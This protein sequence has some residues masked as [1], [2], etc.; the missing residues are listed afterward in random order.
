MNFEYLPQ[1]IVT[2]DGVSFKFG[3]TRELIRE[4]LSELH[5]EDDK[6]VSF[7]DSDTG[8]KLFQ[9]RDVYQDHKPEMSLFFLGY[10][11]LDLLTEIEIHQCDQIKVI[12]SSFSFD[13][14]LDSIAV[15]LNNYSIGVKKGKGEYFFKDLG[16][17]ILDKEEMGGDGNT[18][19]YFYCSSDVSH[20]I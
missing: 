13:Q 6:G 18:L 9:R 15:D 14:D 7:D 11:K 1:G 20:L 5:K 8:K 10:N 4:K 19:G 12:N 16:I 3:D 17:V 2:I